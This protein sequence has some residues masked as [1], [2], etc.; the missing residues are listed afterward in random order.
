MRSLF[1]F[2]LYPCFWE[3]QIVFFLFFIKPILNFLSV[4]N[5]PFSSICFLI[6]T[7][8]VLWLL[9]RL[10][11][12]FLYDLIQYLRKARAHLLFYCC[13]CVPTSFQARRLI[14]ESGLSLS[15]LEQEAEGIDITI[16][17]A[18]EADDQLT[19]IKVRRKRWTILSTVP[20]KLTLSLNRTANKFIRFLKFFVNF[21]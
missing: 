4:G 1:S 3:T 11:D 16:D 5:F 17:G 18:D 2:F 6:F 9:T 14:L 13:R 12:F 19:L 10:K 21:G 8:H 15:D 7:V 20:T